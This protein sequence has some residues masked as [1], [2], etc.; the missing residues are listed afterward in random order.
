MLYSIKKYP[1]TKWI[2]CSV[3]LFGIGWVTRRELLV[4]FAVAAGA[5]SLV[6]G[7]ILAM[8]ALFGYL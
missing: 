3:N 6:Y 8:G 5:F 4:L 2:D 1:E 7:V